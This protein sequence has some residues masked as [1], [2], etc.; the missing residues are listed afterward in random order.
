MTPDQIKMT[1]YWE[2]WEDLKNPDWKYDEAL[3][4]V[5]EREPIDCERCND[6]G[7]DLAEIRDLVRQIDL[8]KK[9]NAKTVREVK[10]LV[11]KIY[12]MKK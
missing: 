10:D 7:F 6:L 11:N 2:R 1:E 8:S 9:W 3:E 4:I 12:E 5:R